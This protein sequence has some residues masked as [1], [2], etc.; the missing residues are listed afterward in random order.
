MTR[1]GKGSIR[2]TKS[3]SGTRIRVTGHAAQALFDALV[4]SAEAQRPEFSPE[5]LVQRPAVNAEAPRA[6]FSTE[7]TR[8]RRP[9]P[10]HGAPKPPGHN[11]VG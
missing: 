7:S 8:H 4:K 6:E 10:A 3:K 11:P 9:N 5:H 1:K 2:I